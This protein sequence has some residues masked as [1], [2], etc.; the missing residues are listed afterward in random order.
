[1]DLKDLCAAAYSDGTVPS[2]APPEKRVRNGRRYTA[3]R[4]SIP[5]DKTA[6]FERQTKS[7]ADIAAYDID[8]T[9]AI[10][11]ESNIARRPRKPNF[12]SKIRFDITEVVVTTKPDE[13][14]KMSTTD[15]MTALTHDDLKT[16]KD[17]LSAQ[18]KLEIGSAVSEM[19]GNS[20][21]QTSNDAFQ[22]N[23]NEQM[24]VQNKVMTETMTTMKEMMM[25]MKE[26]MESKTKAYDRSSED[27][28]DYFSGDSNRDEEPDMEEDQDDFREV[29]DFDRNDNEEIEDPSTS[30]PKRSKRSAPRTQGESPAAKKSNSQ[31]AGG[32]GG[33]GGRGKGG[34]VRER[35]PPPKRNGRRSVRKNLELHYQPLSTSNASSTSGL[36]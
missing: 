23:I 14:T 12:V 4:T 7:W 18:F 6:L 25:S 2:A 13:E 34:R 26:L 22:A 32:N 8:A 28:E 10:H 11:T 29:T 36:N 3:G 20:T 30:S 33:R 9:S 35:T 17:E 5:D 1:M 31:P 21:Q 19:S 24:R 15:T 16:L 27:E